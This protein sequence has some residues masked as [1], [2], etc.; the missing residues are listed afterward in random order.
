MEESNINISRSAIRQAPQRV[1]G[2]SIEVELAAFLDTLRETSVPRV[3]GHILGCLGN[4][5]WKTATILWCDSAWISWNFAYCM[6]WKWG[7]IWLNGVQPEQETQER[8]F[9]NV[10]P[11]FL[12]GP[13]L[14]SFSFKNQSNRL[15]SR[16]D[17][18]HSVSGSFQFVAVRQKR[19]SEPL[20]I[21]FWWTWNPV[22]WFLLIGWSL[23]FCKL[24]RSK[25]HGYQVRVTNFQEAAR[26][27]LEQSVAADDEGKDRGLGKSYAAHSCRFDLLTYNFWTSI[28]TRNQHFATHVIRKN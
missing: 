15:S 19:R 14:P 23:L 1:V 18:K 3:F 27:E 12:F 21:S 17:F 25:K 22:I 13:T 10:D 11:I 9:G 24:L 28:W 8:A 16:V 6:S 4:C 26:V 7:W 2:P 5:T 20:T